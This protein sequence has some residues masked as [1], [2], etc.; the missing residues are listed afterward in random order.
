M[1]ATGSVKL[2]ILHLICNMNKCRLSFWYEYDSFILFFIIYFL[3]LLRTTKGVHTN[4]K[5]LLSTNLVLDVNTIM[6][7]F[8]NIQYTLNV[9]CFV[10]TLESFIKTLF[11][12]TES[13]L[14]GLS[15]LYINLCEND[16]SI[17]RDFGNKKIG[18][19]I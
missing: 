3:E 1:S 16:S 12:F 17:F 7:L 19:I 9:I 18:L 13:L 4:L 6:Q 8:S 14:I 2:L 5:L 10:L 15:V 11:F